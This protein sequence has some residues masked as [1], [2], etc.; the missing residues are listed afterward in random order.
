MK[1]LSLFRSFI[2]IFI[3]FNLSFSLDKITFSD[4]SIVF[5]K[6]IEQTKEYL[7]Y[8]KGDQELSALKVDVRVV[9]LDYDMDK[10]FK[11]SM[12]LVDV[13]K[14][15]DYIKKSLTSFPDAKYNKI[16]YLKVLFLKNNFAIAEKYLADKKE[17]VFVIYKSFIT[18]KNSGPDAAL[19][20]IKNVKV[21]D[22]GRDDG[23]SY[24]FILSLIYHKKKDLK[25]AGANIRSAMRRQNE[26]NASLEFKYFNSE[27]TLEEYNADIIEVLGVPKVRGSK[28]IG[29]AIDGKIK[30]IR[31]YVDAGG[32]P[33]VKDRDGNTMFIHAMK[34]RNKELVNYL[35]DSGASLDLMTS[36]GELAMNIAISLGFDDIAKKM[37]PLIN[38]DKVDARNGMSALVMASYKGRYGL[39]NYF[40]D[41]G[42]NVTNKTRRGVTAFLYIVQRGHTEIFNKLIEKG[43][44]I[45]EA[46]NKGETALY[47][48]IYKRKF[49][50]AKSLIKKGADLNLASTAGYTPLILAARYKMTAIATDLIN[51]GCDINVHL[52]TRNKQSALTFAKS[53]GNKELLALLIEKGAK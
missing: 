30:N 31:E 20:E 29:W 10:F 12:K 34:R 22:L 40:I 23:M 51:A 41:A 43:V 2:L 9:E 15:E 32:D 45:N 25:N 11:A 17:P 50:L 6:I 4:N 13:D 14:K 42:A 27:K 1:T 8:I 46:N 44:D 47:I 3:L 26:G 48:S 35:I 33:D 52:K 21:R 28:L 18:F 49:N 5:C 24:Y 36:R 39:V 19:K 37:T 7:V 16:G 38:I 53:T